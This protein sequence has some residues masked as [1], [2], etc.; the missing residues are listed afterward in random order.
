M[1][2]TQTLIDG[3]RAKYPNHV[4]ALCTNG[5]VGRW[6][7]QRYWTGKVDHHTGKGRNLVRRK[8]LL[9]VYPPTFKLP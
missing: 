9:A 4:V 3:L 2:E 1:N 6:V 7:V 5:N 8:I